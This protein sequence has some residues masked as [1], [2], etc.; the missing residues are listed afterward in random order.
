MVLLNYSKPFEVHTDAS[1]YAI[2]GMLKQD[3]H[4]IALRVVS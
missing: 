1:D 3:G 4:P 2:G